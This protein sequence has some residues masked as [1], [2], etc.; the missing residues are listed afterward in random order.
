MRFPHCKLVVGPLTLDVLAIFDVFFRAEQSAT[1]I[2][3]MTGLKNQ[4]NID[5]VILDNVCR[6]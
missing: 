5:E 4:N 3:E 6:C 1:Q 2:K